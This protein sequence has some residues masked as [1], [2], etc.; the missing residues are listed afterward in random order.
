MRNMILFLMIFFSSQIFAAAGMMI[1]G[2]GRGGGDVVQCYDNQDISRYSGLYSL[3]YLLTRENDFNENSSEH[4]RFANYRSGVDI[5]FEIATKLEEVSPRA[6]KSLLSFLGLVEN[7][8]WA[9]NDKDS[10]VF[11]IWIPAPRL[12]DYKDEDFINEL[13]QNCYRDDGNMNIMQ[14]ILREDVNS[15][16]LYHYNKK[17]FNELAGTPLQ[18]SYLLIHEWLRDYTVHA[19]VIRRVTNFLHSQDFFEGQ[20]YQSLITI[21]RMGIYFNQD[22]SKVPVVQL[23]DFDTGVGCNGECGYL[24]VS[25][26]VKNIAYHKYVAIYYSENGGPWSELPAHYVRQ[27]SHGHEEWVIETNFGKS[28]HSIEFAVKYAVGGQIYWDNNQNANYSGVF[29][30]PN[31]TTY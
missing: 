18:M 19:S 3:D 6:S 5:A 16:I 13:P 17:L 15:N 10:D 24:E 8:D 1:N 23:M 26:K 29:R 9:N 25:I 12:K 7:T 14:L 2:D 11:R 22:F 21:Q 31:E 4:F 30:Y 27:L 28:G 20:T